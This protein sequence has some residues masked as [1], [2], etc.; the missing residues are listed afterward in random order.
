MPDEGR[1]TERCVVDADRLRWSCDPS[2]FGFQDTSELDDCPIEI[3][4]QPRAMAALSLGLE[5]RSEGYNIFV[6]GEVGTGRSTTVRRT[7]ARKRPDEEAPPDLVYVH[8]FQDPDRPRLLT[9]PAGGGR[10]FRDAMAEVVGNLGNL[11]PRLFESSTYQERRTRLIDAAKTEHRAALK[12]FEERSK[13]AGF[14]LA[15]IQM[16]EFVR[17]EFVPLIDDKP[18]GLDDLE[19]AAERGEFDRERFEHLKEEHG[20]L[21]REMGVVSKE[22]RAIQRRLGRQ[23]SELDREIA[24]VPGREAVEDLRDEFQSLAVREYLDQ[25]TDDVLARLQVFRRIT[26]SDPGE[27]DLDAEAELEAVLVPYRVNVL[28]DNAGASGRPIL[29]ETSPS[30]RNLFGTVE[31]VADPSGTSDTDHTRIKAGSLVRANGG[32]LV[33]DALDL[34]VEP[35]VWPALKRTLRTHELEI[36]SYDPRHPQVGS[37]LQPEPIPLD[38]KV[39]MIGTHQIHR[40]LYAL[41]EDFKKIFKIKADFALRTER[42]DEERNNYACFIHKKVKDDGLPHFTA[43]GVAAVVEHGVRIAGRRDKLTTQ[44]NRI[45]DLIREAG[46]WA[47]LGDAEQVD[48]RHVDRAIEERRYRHDLVEEVLRQRIADG[49]VLIDLEGERVGQVNGLVVLDVGDYTFGQPSRITATSAMGRAGILDIDRE[50]EMSGPIHAKGVLI[51]AGFLRERFAQGRPLTL[52]A[53]LC[54]EQN[55]GLVEGDS[56]SC[57]ELFALLSSLSGIPI[58]QG[59]AM[60][61]SVDQKGEVQPIGGVNQ[62]I[63]GFFDLCLVRGLDG[64]NGVVIPRRNLDDLMLRKDIVAAV[65]EGRFRVWAIGNIEEGIEILTGVPAGTRDDDGRFSPATVFGKVDARLAAL[66]EGIKEFGPADG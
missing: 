33:V 56:A 20:R 13:E 37:A 58:R 66:A 36:Q 7:I 60:T 64:G 28:V 41:D 43:A 50:S 29:W 24:R 53:S 47:H 26:E 38:I 39:V 34:L 54:F 6:A 15:Q 55:Y 23:L 30:F 10:R 51:L 48:A 1:P 32:F 62:K 65:R 11:L 44:F 8:N 63:E 22:V 57:A 5:I 27:M 4:G 25:A 52:S 21:T 40:Q 18:V 42:S 12:V 9:F 31:R 49:T 35:G 16:G 2:S 17:P 61:G 14:A 19:D 45:A 3:I 46:Y 59:I